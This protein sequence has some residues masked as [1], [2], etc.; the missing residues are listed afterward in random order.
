[1]PRRSRQWYM[2]KC[3]CQPLFSAR[4]EEE[5]AARLRV[6]AA[7][8]DG[9]ALSIEKITKQ[10]HIDAQL[11]LDQQRSNAKSNIATRHET[12]AHAHTVVFLSIDD[13]FS[14]T[15]T[16]SCKGP[17]DK[18]IIGDKPISKDTS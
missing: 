18:A 17:S 2:D 1:M 5:V 8:L 3:S 16:A 12:H 9:R 13:F 14:L 11:H 4:Y 6:P 10:G 7:S 15:P